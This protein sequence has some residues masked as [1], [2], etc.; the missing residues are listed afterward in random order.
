MNELTERRNT[1]NCSSFQYQTEK[2]SS[3]YMPSNDNQVYTNVLVREREE[4]EPRKRGSGHINSVQRDVQSED[5]S[6]SLEQLGLAK[7]LLDRVHRITINQMVIDLHPVKKIGVHRHEME[8][9]S[10]DDTVIEH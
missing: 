9:P 5:D 1:K 10:K 8:N 3:D 2:C 4:V 6:F 7:R